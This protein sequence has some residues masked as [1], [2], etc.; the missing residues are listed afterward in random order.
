MYKRQVVDKL[1]DKSTL[2][3]LNGNAGY[4]KRRS[5]AQKCSLVLYGPSNLDPMKDREAYYFSFLL[6]HKPFWDESLLKGP[7][8]TYQAEFERL[9]DQL[10][11]MAAHEAKV[12]RRKNF[13]SDMDKEAE[14]AADETLA[15]EADESKSANLD[16]ESDIFETIR[17]Q[18][19]VETEEQL[20]EAVAGLSPDQLAVYNLF[21]Q[22][23]DHY[24]QHNTKA[25][26][27]DDFEPVRLFVSG[28]GGS[29]KSHLIRTLMAY[30]FIRS[31]VKKEPCHF[32][33]GAP[34]GIASH[35]IGGMTLHS[36]WS[37]PVDHSNCL[38]Y[39]SPSPRD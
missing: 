25:C 6:L 36:M 39:T 10:P 2:L 30:Q 7:S 11:A 28:F 18:T 19:T 22:N 5:D 20:N 3:R 13:R 16:Y 38:L 33:L 4:M 37:L 8:D 29:G 34:T 23:V 9:R 21:V 17:K 15:R 24:Y 35:N 14:A 31:E 1:K 26:C 32:L 27:C 12:R